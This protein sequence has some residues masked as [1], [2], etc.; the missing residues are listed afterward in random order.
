MKTIYRN[1]LAA[2]VALAAAGSVQA[3]PTFGSG[4]NTIFF[5][6]FEN[7]YR[8]DANCVGGGCLGAG[9]GPAGYQLVDPSVAGNVDVGDVFAGVFNVQNINAVDNIWLQGATD[10]FSGYFAQEVTDIED[11]HGGVTP[12]HIVLGNPTADPFGI[13]AAGEMFRIYVDDGVGS[14]F[15]DGVAATVGASITECTDGGLW[16]SLGAGATVNDALADLDGYAYSHTDLSIPGNLSDVNAFLALDLVT[17]GAEYNAGALVKVNDGNENEIG[18][19]LAAVTTD[20]PPGAAAFITCTDFVGTSEIEGNPFFGDG[21]PWV[22]RSDD[23]FEFLRAVPEPGMLGLLGLGLLG[24]GAKR[25]R[26]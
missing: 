6:N 20:C 15:C 17:L 19:L 2:A 25:R 16:A 21:S 4:L 22:F 5:F 12:D 8:T 23:P 9:T 3:A 13:L 7:L 26:S 18:G 1:A 14:T 24:L 11:I 10:H